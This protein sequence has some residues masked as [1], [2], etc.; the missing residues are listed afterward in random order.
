VKSLSTK[1]KLKREKEDFV[2]TFHRK[3]QMA[4]GRK[5][6]LYCDMKQGYNFS[7]Y[8]SSLALLRSSLLQIEIAII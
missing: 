6:H 4:L 2:Y 5:M 3:P 7:T 8:Y 1:N